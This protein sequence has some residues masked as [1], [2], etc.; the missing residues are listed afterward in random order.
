[1][2]NEQGRVNNFRA[3]VL[4]LLPVAFLIFALSAAGNARNTDVKQ[5]EKD[6]PGQ[7][8]IKAREAYEAKKYSL[9]RDELKQALTL[10]KEMPQA[11]L[12]LAMTYRVE[13]NRRTAIEYVNNAIKY[14]PNYPDAH[15]ILSLLMFETNNRDKALQEIDLSIAQGARFAAAFYL[16]G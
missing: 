11:H 10:D 2:S 6:A 13:G 5:A 9:V 7:H 15:Y 4:K 12:L 1:M 16:R 14:R 3:T 8:L